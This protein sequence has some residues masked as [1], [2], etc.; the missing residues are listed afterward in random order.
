MTEF[1]AKSVVDAI[2]RMFRGHH[3]SICK[4]DDCMKVTGATRTADYDSL[5]LY[6]CVNYSEMDDETKDFL[7]KATLE[8]VCNTS[9]FPT[10]HLSPPE[11]KVREM[12]TVE[13]RPFL[14]RLFGGS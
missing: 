8:N 6:H 4:V 2:N 7:F 1:Q 14:Q 10:L 5:R 12:L 13:K 3:F 11:S 9:E